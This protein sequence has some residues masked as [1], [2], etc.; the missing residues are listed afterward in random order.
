MS[1]AEEELV[2]DDV[3]DNPPDTETAQVDPLEEFRAA[4]RATG[5]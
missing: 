4:L 1:E 5:T 3:T 2:P